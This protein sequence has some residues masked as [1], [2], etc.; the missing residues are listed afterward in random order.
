MNSSSQILVAEDDNFTQMAVKMLIGSLKKEAVIAPD[1]E[2]AVKTFKEKY[3]NF[4]LV[5]M[6]L[7]MPKVDGFEAAKKIRETEKSLGLPP[8]KMF[9]ISAG[10]IFQ[11]S[12]SL[13]LYV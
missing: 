8:I 12:K 3:G 4:G 10:K 9:G 13:N 7:H 6:D 5:L 2:V 1:G 11:Y